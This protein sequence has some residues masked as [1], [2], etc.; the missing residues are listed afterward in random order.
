MTGFNL[1]MVHFEMQN[2][3]SF[4]TCTEALKVAFD[5]GFRLD[6]GIENGWLHYASTTAQGDIWIAA[7]S[8]SGPW[9]MATNHPGVVAEL[10]SST[11]IYSAPGLQSFEVGT[12]AELYAL[13]DRAYRLGVSLPNVPLDLFK[14]KTV[15][16]PQSTE[17]ERLVIQRVGQNIFR[18]ALIDYWGGSCAVSDVSELRLLRA[19]HIKPWKECESDIERLDVFNGI[20]L[21]AHLDAAFDAG[22]ISFDDDGAIIASETFSIG[23]RKALGIGPELALKNVTPQHQTNLAWHRSHIFIN[24]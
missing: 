13:V 16:L 10:N 20:L 8:D 7:V 19:S 18:D 1:T 24:I 4:I 9:F 14:K 11:E 17:T 12:M 5:N 21:A 3:P 22:L 23:D 2:P 15:N 6:L